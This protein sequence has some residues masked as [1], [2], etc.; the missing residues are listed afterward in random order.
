MILEEGSQMALQQLLAGFQS[1]QQLAFS[2]IL[3]STPEFAHKCVK[4]FFFPPLLSFQRWN[5]SILRSNSLKKNEIH[6][7]SQLVAMEI[8]LHNRTSAGTRCKKLKKLLFLRI[9]CSKTHAIRRLFT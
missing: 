7:L 4:P 8:V 9:T 1:N 5:Y 2:K 3:I 6:F